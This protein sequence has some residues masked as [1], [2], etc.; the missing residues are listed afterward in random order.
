MIP[1]KFI[2]RHFAFKVAKYKHKIMKKTQLLTLLSVCLLASCSKTNKNNQN[3]NNFPNTPGQTDVDPVAS[4][5]IRLN[6]TSVNLVANKSVQLT[7]TVTGTNKTPTW[8]VTSGSNFVSVSS[9]GLVT[10]ISVGQA[11]VTATVEGKSASC[12]W[13]FPNET[14]EL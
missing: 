8:S 11:T 1:L 6:K 2:F 13:N 3:S 12:L 5:T 4:V 9:S 10:A 14:A 7:A